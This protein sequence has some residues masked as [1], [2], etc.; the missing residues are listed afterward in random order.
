[1]LLTA[2]FSAFSY[3]AQAQYL[4]AKDIYKYAKSRNYNALSQISRYI[5]TQDGRGNTAL[6]L[7]VID[8][9]YQTYNLLRQYG[10]NPQPYCLQS[11]MAANKSGTFLGMGTAGWL[12]VGAVVA[13]GAGVAVAAGGGGG[14]GSGSSSS[15][16]GNNS[17]NSGGDNSGSGGSEDNSATKYLDK[18]SITDTDNGQEIV[19]KSVSI[20]NFENETDYLKAA[21]NG[22]IKKIVSS[23]SA[24]SGIVSDSQFTFNAVSLGGNK[25]ADIIV[26]QRGSGNVYGIKG[27][28]INTLSDDDDDGINVHNAVIGDPENGVATG[29]VTGNITIRN[30]GAGTGNLYGMQ[31]D[32]KDVYVVN[33]QAESQ[34]NSATATGNIL[35]DN[36]NSNKNVY[37]IYSKAD[38]MN[39]ETSGNAKAYGNITINNSGN[40]NVLGIQTSKYNTANAGAVENS[41]ATASITINNSGSGDVYGINTDEVSSDR[42]LLNAV[43]TNSAVANGNITIRN[44]GAGT[45]NIYGL[46]AKGDTYVGN[47]V[48][49]QEL[50]DD[51]YEMDSSTSVATGNISVE[52]INSNKNVYGI[53]AKADSVNAESNDNDKAYG[54]I[55]IKNSGNGNVYGIQ[56]SKDNTRNASATEKSEATA[57]IDINNTGNGNVYGINEDVSYP[58]KDLYNA[59]AAER[60]SHE[61]DYKEEYPAKATATINIDNTGTGNVFGIKALTEIYN[62]H[63]YY[64]STATGKIRISNNGSGDAYGIFGNS[65]IENAI[66]RSE[67]LSNHATAKGYVNIIN[68]SSG[69]AYGLYS[70]VTGNKISNNSGSDGKTQKS[71]I[72]LANIGNGLAVGIYS[73]DGTV[74]NSGDIKIHNL[75]DGYAVGIYADGTTNATNSGT[76]T[77]DR[78]SYKDDMATDDVSDDK[79]YTANLS[80]GGKAV[81]IYGAAGS[82]ITNTG[83]IKIN[84][85]KTAYGIYIEGS[86]NSVSNMGTILIDGQYTENAIKLNGSQLFQNGVL[87]M[88]ADW[89]DGDPCDSVTCGTNATCSVV[90]NSGVCS[91]NSGYEGNPNTGCT[92][93]AENDDV[94][95]EQTTKN[96]GK[97]LE[98]V[99]EDDGDE[100]IIYYV[101]N[102]ENIKLNTNSDATVI[103][104][105]IHSEESAN[106]GKTGSNNAASINIKQTGNGLVYGIQSLWD[107]NYDGWVDN[108]FAEADTENTNTQS[109]TANSQ[110]LINILNLGNGNVYGMTAT[111]LTNASAYASIEENGQTANANATGRIRIL[112]KG[113]GDIYGMYSNGTM[114]NAE[115]RIDQVSA[116]GTITVNATGIISLINEGSGKTYGMYA[117]KEGNYIH[118][119]N[120]QNATSTIE[121]VNYDDN[122]LAIGIYSKDGTVENSGEIKIHNLGSGTAVGIYADGSTNV[123]NSGKIMIDRSDYTDD[124]AT[125]DTSDDFTYTKKSPE[126]GTAIGI[127]GADGSTITNSGEIKIN[128]AE[129]AYGIYTE[130]SESSVINNGTILINGQSSEN[131]IRTN[132]GTL[133][134]DGALIVTN[135]SQN[136]PMSVSSIQPASLNLNDFGGTV[137]ASDTSQ[138]IVEGS[139]SGDLAINNNVIENGFDTTYSVKDMIQ[140]GDTSGLNLQSKSALFNATL[141]N[142]TD[143]VM[144]MKA[145]NDVVENSSVADFLQNNYAANNNEDLFKVLKSAETVVQ[146]NNNIDDLFGKDMLSRMAF[147]DLSMLRE[148]SFDMNNHLFEK[149]GAFAFG[150]SISPSSYDNNI[151]SVGRYSLNGYNNGKISFGLGV[152]ITD[153]RTNDGKNDNSRFDRSFMMSAPIGYKTHGFELITA[154][155]MGYTDGTYDRDGFNNKTYEG[156]IQKRMFALMNEA[157]YPLKFGGLKLLP[158]AEFNMIGYNIKGHEDEQQYA[159]RIKSQNHYSVEAGLGLMAEKEFKPFKNH[160]FSVN[161]GVTVYHEFANPYE[162]DVA[163]SGM[164]G[165]YRLHDEKRSDNRTVARFGFNYK[166]KDNLDVSASWLTNIDREYRTDASIDMKYHF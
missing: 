166:L 91:C 134:Q 158:S 138:F 90:G 109:A 129:I 124:K 93:I 55:A 142:D 147:E 86:E 13:V 133:F 140:A 36:I 62:A 25:D 72:E 22:T 92:L 97:S 117:Q 64:N 85:A 137:V 65:V 101:H 66:A 71:V 157:R 70:N 156:K 119:N 51:D 1:M 128:K 105:R 141:E 47:A 153:V 112:N 4:S 54:Y 78:E 20:S 42:F 81:G 83:T 94:F 8:D 114:K 58:N 41:K 7:A 63:S 35:I 46:R 88:G 162:L 16:S 106:A 37:G 135:N 40:G 27:L 30:T 87:R 80:I 110:A 121:I 111:D 68:K 104:L 96:I 73:E 102:N 23:Q 82:H 60:K 52:N 26:A 126:G 113:S 53:Y 116:K 69:N 152:S 67:G 3:M 39:T 34:S 107:N 122:G 76:I 120:D 95:G 49:I 139:I 163:M 148:V 50:W 99:A 131:A 32:A 19:G 98:G 56:T 164:S 144:T 79:T 130:G 48:G 118:N 9:D 44:T 154:P 115:A 11:A 18:E 33:S 145:F 24:V 2:V 28:K 6:C 74:E 75:A 57:R 100:T 161:G 10:A 159:L 165:T 61:G 151:G 150:E 108:A 123:T 12:T 125:T 21:N 89:G 5:D 15:G 132:G 59:Q 149:E 38:A 127:Y 77:I 155:K 103:G 143:A 45:G 43:A 146:L 136:S 29:N 160:K 17:N 14:G 31:A 84:G